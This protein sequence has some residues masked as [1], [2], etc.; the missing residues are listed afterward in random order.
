MKTQHTLTQPVTGRSLP[1]Q[2]V[3]DTDAIT[4]HLI[5][6][7]AEIEADP[8]AIALCLIAAAVEM[9]AETIPADMMAG[10]LRDVA[11]AITTP[12]VS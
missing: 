2:Q 10:Y 11:R 5:A 12:Q 9:A 1:P 3:P 8:E 4:D 6:A 7:A